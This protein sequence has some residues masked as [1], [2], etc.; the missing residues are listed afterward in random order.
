M[1]LMLS[2]L[3]LFLSLL[4]QM[5]Y[6][7]QP[8]VVHDTLC[9]RIMILGVSLLPSPARSV[10]AR[11]DAHILT[12]GCEVE[13][14]RKVYVDHTSAAI[15]RAEKLE[16]QRADKQRAN[17][18][19]QVCPHCFYKWTLIQLASGCDLRNT[20]IID[21]DLSHQDS[22]THLWTRTTRLL[23]SRDLTSMIA[24]MYW[25][26]QASANTCGF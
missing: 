6:P 15:R 19:Q 21:D 7:R 5:L 10:Q 4:S 25:L 16:K 18:A 20:F 12:S 14:C 8:V 9:A 2:G 26:V 1:R 13:S 23:R 22:N 11:C 3:L 17:N 24:R